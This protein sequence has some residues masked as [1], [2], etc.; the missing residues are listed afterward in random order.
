MLLTL[1]LGLQYNWLAQASDAERERMQ[2][3][4]D[5][6][7]KAFAD[8]FNREIQAAYFNFQTDAA[9]WEKA[10]YTEFNE[11]YEYWKSKT[12]YPELISEFVFFGK[13]PAQ[14]LKYDPVAKTFF[15]ADVPA[16]LASLRGNGGP[17]SVP[18][19]PVR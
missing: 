4:V 14:P 3:R 2:R 16:D 11:R 7:T 15:A 13:E 17:F 6:D 1:F 5:A 10:D 9:T 12:Q 8:D 19:V 18:G